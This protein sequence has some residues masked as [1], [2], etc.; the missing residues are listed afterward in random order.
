VVGEEGFKLIDA[1][2]MGGPL[3]SGGPLAGEIR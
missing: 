3:T 1:F 2:W